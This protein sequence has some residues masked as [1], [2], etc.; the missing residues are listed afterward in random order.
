MNEGNS[1]IKEGLSKA[2]AENEFYGVAVMTLLLGRRGDALM[3]T[4]DVVEK[5]VRNPR[6]G[7]ELMELLLSRMVGFF[8]TGDLLKAAAENSESGSALLRM[9]L[10]SASSGV[11]ITEAVIE[12]ALSNLSIERE[13]VTLLFSRRTT[14]VPVTEAIV[15][16]AIRNWGN[17][18]EFM[19]LLLER[20][21][22][23]SFEEA[24]VV[25]IASLRDKDV[26]KLVFN[27]P[28]NNVPSTELVA[29]Q[30][31]RYHDHEMMSCLLNTRK[32]SL[33]LTEDITKAA[34]RNER[35]GKAI[36]MLLVSQIQDAALLG[37]RTIALI[38]GLFDEE[39][40]DRLLQLHGNQLSITEN[41]FEAA[42]QNRRNGQ[43]VVQ[44]LLGW[45]T[46]HLPMTERILKAAARNRASG[47]EAIMAL[48]LKHQTSDVSLTE[49]ILVAVAGNRSYGSELMALLLRQETG[50][51]QITEK[52]IRA[53][54]GNTVSGPIVLRM[55]RASGTDHRV[56]DTAIAE[57]TRLWHTNFKD[58]HSDHAPMGIPT[59]TATTRSAGPLHQQAMKTLHLTEYGK[60][61]I[62][63]A[64]VL[65]VAR[66]HEKEAMML[67][68]SQSANQ[69]PITEEITIQITKYFDQDVML[70]LF[71]FRRDEI[72]I[73]EHLVKAA[74]WNWHSGRAVFLA[75]LHE[76][77]H[78]LITD[79][80]E[81]EIIRQFDENVTKILLDRR[82]DTHTVTVGLLAAAAANRRSEKQ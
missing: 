55:L 76:R 78:L 41:V 66:T 21:A 7:A 42:V 69:M 79:G 26:L 54:A 80:A 46:T 49:E 68:I 14:K 24:V 72:M 22:H 6:C 64:M 62:T 63:E 31:A 59:A 27:Q 48:L 60:T 61:S 37:E 18:K 45:R 82:G 34:A 11:A 51:F 38:L 29:V 71:R 56:T 28:S 15:R 10:T 43:A 25:P 40:T 2:A 3:I 13:V 81:V 19:V 35:C 73:T 75:L 36:M 4:N 12:T 47:S 33:P 57:I 52:V 58:A 67:L 17:R 20:R 5:A 74:A 53:A 30:F 50:R 8:N 44:V 65:C 39:I 70:H 1:I 9:L 16:A 77:Q 23:E 32:T